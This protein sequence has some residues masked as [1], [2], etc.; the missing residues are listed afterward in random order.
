MSSDNATNV[1]G[2]AL[3]VSR[4]N[5]DGTIASGASASYVSKKFVSIGFTPELESGDEL[6]IK[7]ADGTIGATWKSPDT[8][9]RFTVALTLVDPDPELTEMLTGGTIFT[10]GGKSV[11]WAAPLPG[12]NPTPNGCAIEVWS[13]ANINGRPSTT[14]PYWRHV[15]PQVVLRPN[16]ERLVG[17]N[18]M[19][20][21]FSGYSVGNANFGTGPGA[22]TWPFTSDSG[23]AYARDTAIPTGSGYVAV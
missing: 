12:V 11:G 18:L 2:V 22:P 20:V 3:R 4:L 1:M 19:G 21:Q 15:L 16:G 5:S 10:A 6:N 9:K 13:Y 7:A 23:W 8:I 17:N 14:N